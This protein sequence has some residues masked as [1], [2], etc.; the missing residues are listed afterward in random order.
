MKNIIIFITALLAISGCSNTK[1]SK[2]ANKTFSNSIAMEFVLIPS[3]SFEMGTDKKIGNTDEFPPHNVTISRNFYLGKFEVTQEQWI[4]IMSSNPSEFKN[5][6]NPVESVN[7]YDVQKFISKLNAL[8]NTTKYRLPTEAEWE[9]AARAASQSIYSFG[10]SA[11]KLASYA[12]YYDKS[13][14]QPFQTHFVGQKKPNKWGLY[15]MHGNVWEWTADWYDSEYYA[16]SPEKDPINN[17]SSLKNI[18]I[19]GGGW[20]NSAEYMRSAVRHHKLPV[21]RE[22][23]LGFRVAFDIE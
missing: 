14:K 20:I 3:G 22:D 8:E 9:Y 19:R 11:D 6:S 1:E 15:D 12:W 13:S 5:N 2:S 7:W 21:A 16:K 17:L 10:D 18:A 23:D 4:K